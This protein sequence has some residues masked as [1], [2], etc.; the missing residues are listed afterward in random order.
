MADANQPLGGTA[1]KPVFFRNT[2]T[3]WNTN[4]N[5]DESLGETAMK[6]LDRISHDIMNILLHDIK[7]TYVWYITYRKD[8]CYNLHMILS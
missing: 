3:N 2:N 1:I 7:P 8:I 4:T 5:S 6:P